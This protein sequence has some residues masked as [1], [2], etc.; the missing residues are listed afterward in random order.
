MFACSVADSFGAPRR[1]GTSHWPAEAGMSSM[2]TYLASTSAALFE[3]QPARPG[4]A[5]GGVAHQPEVVGDRLRSDP[6]LRADPVGI[7]DLALATVVLHH[8]PADDALA[9]VLVGGDDQ[10]LLDPLVGI[11]ERGRGRQRVV[12][13]VFDHRP[14]DEAGGGEG[15]L[16]HR[17]LFEDLRVH[18]GAGLVPGPE[19]VAE[20][21]DHVIGRHPDVRRTFL[22]ERERRRDHSGRRRVRVAVG[23]PG[24]HPEVLTKE[25]VGPVDQMDTHGAQPYDAPAGP[26]SASETPRRE[27]VASERGDQSEHD[28]LGADAG[29]VPHPLRVGGRLAHAPPESGWPSCPS[30]CRATPFL[31]GISW[32]PI[33]PPPGP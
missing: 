28:D 21:L 24:G 2:W 27:R 26:V 6:E 7:D 18:P 11:G 30:D 9:E 20:A 19:I 33:R 22:D 12:G 1:P 3:P 4:E 13:L 25:F 31:L 10:H 17:D 14:D 16:H 32:K 8:P 23:V 15:P 29:P 5:V